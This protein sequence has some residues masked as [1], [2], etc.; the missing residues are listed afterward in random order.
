MEKETDS[1][2]AEYKKITFSGPS[3]EG[4]KYMFFGSFVQDPRNAR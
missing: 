4:E 2:F 3:G 1:P